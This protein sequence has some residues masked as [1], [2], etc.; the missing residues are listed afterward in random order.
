MNVKFADGQYLENKGLQR[1]KK[2]KIKFVTECTCPLYCI[3]IILVLHKSEVLVF[4]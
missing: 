3:F 2:K 1:F 4:R